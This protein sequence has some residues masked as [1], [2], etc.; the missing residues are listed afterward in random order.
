MID[1]LEK[2]ESARAACTRAPSAPTAEAHVENL[3][4]LEIAQ[5]NLMKGINNAE[6]ALAE[7][8][9]TVSRLRKE[10]SALEVSDPA[11]EHELDAST[12]VYMCSLV[13]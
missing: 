6:G 5:R 9:G 4:A 12:C 3:N 8:E 11:V 13:S 1:Q 2:L 7:K 10:R